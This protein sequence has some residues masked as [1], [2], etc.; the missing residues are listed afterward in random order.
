MDVPSF[1][2]YGRVCAL[3]GL[4][5]G[6]ARMCQRGFPL[7]TIG[8]ATFTGAAANA[9]S[10]QVL[11]LDG[12]GSYMELPPNLFRDLRQATVE[13]WAKWDSFP[14]FAR[15]FEFGAG[16]NSISLFNHADTSDLRFNIYSEHAQFDTSRQ[17]IIRV[18][19]LLRTNEWI[20]LAAVSGPHGMKLYANGV[21]VGT[22]RHEGSFASIKINQTN[23]VGRGL[24]RNPNDRDFHGQIDELRVW[25]HRRTTA[26]IREN[27]FK[28]LTGREEGLVHLWNF[29]AGTAADAAANAGKGKLK[30][31]AE[32]VAG[33]PQ[34]AM[35]LA[36]S[37]APISAPP[38]PVTNNVIAL[39]ATPGTSSMAAWWIAGALVG[40]VAV[41]TWLVL[42]LRRS[43]VGTS[44]LVPAGGSKSLPGAT[45]ES[46]PP[47][48]QEEVRQRALAELTDFAKESLVQGLYSQRQVLAE[49]Q[50]RAQQEL[51][52]LE[53]RLVALQ[54]PERI[55]AYQ[56][57]IAE[58][59]RDLENRGDEL[60]ELTRQ[61]L[62]LL[63]QKL[64]EEK[65]SAAKAS[66]FN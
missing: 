62:T 25:D 19:A 66:R 52:E 37:A 55:Q 49:A 44:A 12:Q 53:A 58:L 8:I 5:V 38:A 48:V 20:H 34:F 47:A 57:R 3:S 11:K 6:L 1:R 60:R 9:A 30:G 4:L 56:S 2:V 24:V 7:L 65:Q 27:M 40:I 63:R 28:R 26:Q 32:I 15:V 39:A 35:E 59:E 61:T 13:V 29:D 17:N 33:G 50:K 21:L 41:L 31:R 42:M 36:A 18:S 45:V 51:A 54:L 16:W 46:L 10:N 23:L 14:A 22:N 64:A 43:G